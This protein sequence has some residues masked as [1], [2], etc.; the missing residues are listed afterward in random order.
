MKKLANLLTMLLVVSL[1][2]FAGEG[3]SHGEEH[4]EV[5]I[6]A[7]L[8]ELWAAIQTE[9]SALVAALEKKDSEGSHKSADALLAYANALPGKVEGLD[10]A[11]RQRIAGQAKNLAKVY[12]D[13]HHAA[14]DSAFEKGLKDSAK[15]SAVLKLL[16]PQL[17]LKT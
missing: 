12:D 10:E 9:Q 13:I 17:P 7:A 1:S 3:H 8:D 16:A 2:A 11:K 4:A 15:A 6:P 14:E 5:A